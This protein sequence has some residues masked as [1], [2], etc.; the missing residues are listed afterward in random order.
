MKPLFILL[1]MMSL[2]NLSFGQSKPDP[3]TAKNQPDTLPTEKDGLKRF[4]I[5]S[6]SHVGV[7]GKNADLKNPKALSQKQDH[8]DN[9]TNGQKRFIIQSGNNIGIKVKNHPGED[10]RTNRLLNAGKALSS[11]EV[12]G[13]TARRFLILPGGN[14]GVGNKHQ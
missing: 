9:I 13:D 6:G 2:T 4:T 8:W 1:L 14:V 10:S 12:N 7:G 5:Y 11:L 3:L